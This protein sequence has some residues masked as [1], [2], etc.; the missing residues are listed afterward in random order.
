MMQPVK[1]ASSEAGAVPIIFLWGPAQIL[2]MMQIVKRRDCPLQIRTR[3][4]AGPAAL[5]SIKTHP[6]AHNEDAAATP[7]TLQN[8]R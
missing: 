6:K 5:E 4:R 8:G 3:D 2:T 1:R 7:P